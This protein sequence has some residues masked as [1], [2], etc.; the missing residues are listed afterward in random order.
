MGRLS[1]LKR[2]DFKSLGS[3]EIRRKVQMTEGR[4]VWRSSEAAHEMFQTLVTH[5][6]GFEVD[7]TKR[8]QLRKL[9]K[10]LCQ[11]LESYRSN[12]VSA[13]IKFFKKEKMRRT[14]EFITNETNGI[15][16]KFLTGKIH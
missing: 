8:H 13:E 7:G 12:L 5:L 14:S 6:I 15:V 11:I 10:C 4:Q 16:I 3:D 9:N 2:K 1:K